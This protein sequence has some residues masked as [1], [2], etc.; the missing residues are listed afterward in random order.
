MHIACML[1]SLS[2]VKILTKPNTVIDL[3]DLQG[4][5]PLHLAC[6]SLND[7]I[8]RYL[9]EHAKASWKVRNNE[10]QTPKAVLATKA[11]QAGQLSRFSQLI[12]SVDSGNLEGSAEGGASS[13]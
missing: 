8:I 13:G 4:N 10:H 5:T 12:E 3:Q 9:T 1:G 6:G 2:M 11:K 7:S